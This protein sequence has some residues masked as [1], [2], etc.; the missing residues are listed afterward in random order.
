MEREK[1]DLIIQYAI[2]TAGMEDSK[3][4]R[5]L[6]PIHLIKYVYLADIAYAE[7]HNGET[8]TCADWTFYKFGPWSQVV[9]ER[10]EPALLAIGA[11][12]ITFP[13]NYDDKD[14]W[15][16]WSIDDEHFFA[17]I[18]KKIPVEIRLKLRMAIRKFG[19]DTPSLLEHV[20]RSKPMLTA[21]PLELLDFSGLSRQKTNAE[22]MPLQRERLTTK[23]NKKLKDSIRALR[24]KFEANYR[25]GLTKI[26]LVNPVPSPRYDDVYEDGLAW[27]ESLAGSPFPEGKRTARFDQA[28]WKSQTRGGNDIP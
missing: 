27:L 12:K 5:Q 14:D 8:F 3:F 24:D 2:L 16:R 6:G 19:K 1:I 21:A 13:S 15:T 11:D 23:R 18:G 7:L 10:I 17:E 22:K 26:E 4:D 25:D 9:H 28:V 20:Y